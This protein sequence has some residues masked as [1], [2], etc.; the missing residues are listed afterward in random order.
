[1]NNWK[2][3]GWEKTA[4]L[5]LILIS[6]PF[7]YNYYQSLV[8]EFKLSVLM[9]LLKQMLILFFFLIRSIP[10]EVTVSPFEWYVGIMG[11][12]VVISFIPVAG[13][14]YIAAEIFQF[15]GLT[16]TT[17]GL[18]SLNTSFGIVPANR[19]VKTA[20]FYR[21][22]RHPLYLGYLVADIGFLINNV[23]WWNFIVAIGVA[24]FL[25]LRIHYEEK[26]LSQD[27]AYKDYMQ[28]T[29]YRLMPGVY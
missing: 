21:Y 15:I 5:L 22:I 25:V 27:E 3:Y 23:F 6:A 13:D 28:Q 11:S 24:F 18:L 1:M 2:K 19:G 14:E 16:I 8:T 17:V 7:V 9:L 26:F 10:K 20:G 12:W 29:R 4:N